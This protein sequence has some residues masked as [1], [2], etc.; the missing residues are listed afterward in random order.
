MALVSAPLIADTATS[1]FQPPR[2]SA[3]VVCMAVTALV[4]SAMDFRRSPTCSRKPATW[5]RI[6]PNSWALISFIEPPE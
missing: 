1:V 3:I 6:S 2:A 5:A 4:M